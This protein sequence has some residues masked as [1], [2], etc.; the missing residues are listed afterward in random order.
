MHSFAPSRLTW[1]ALALLISLAIISPKQ[2]VAVA[3]NWAGTGNWD[4][5][6]NWGGTVP[7]AGDSGAINTGTAT[8]NVVL[9]GSPTIT[10]G[11]TGT[12]IHPSFA[13]ATP[14][15]G[16]IT[17]QSGGTID[18]TGA[19]V[20]DQT[21]TFFDGGS[22]ITRSAGD[23]LGQVVSNPITF[24]AGTTTITGVAGSVDWS[25]YALT[26]TGSISGGVSANFNVSPTSTSFRNAFQI[27]PSVANSY[28]GT[29]TVSGV[30][31]VHGVL[32]LAGTGALQNATG[33][34]INPNGVLRLNTG[35]DLLGA[36]A[37]PVV[38][39]ARLELGGHST[40]SGTPPTF[41][42]Q[43]GS[44]L[45][46]GDSDIQ[47]ST[48]ATMEVLGGQTLNATGILGSVDWSP[49]ALTLKGSLQGSGLLNV[50]PTATNQKG[51]LRLS[52]TVANSFTGTVAIGGTP[53]IK[54]TLILEGTG[55]LQNIGAGAITINPYGQLRINTSTDPLPA[56]YLL[57]VNADARMEWGGTATYTGVKPTI[58]F[59]N[60]ST[61]GRGDGDLT[62]SIMTENI[63]INGTVKA[64]KIDGTVDWQPYGLKLNGALSGSGTLRIEP[65]LTGGDKNALVIN[66][67][68]ANSFNGTVQV[69]GNAVSRGTLGLEGTGAL[70]NVSVLTVENFGTIR[71]GSA[72][73]PLPSAFVVNVQTGGRAEWLGTA[74]YNVTPPTLLLQN[75]TFLGRSQNDELGTSKEVLSLA[76]GATV[77]A[78]FRG[79][80]LREF[81]APN[82]TGGLIGDNTTTLHVAPP[83]VGSLLGVMQISS[84]TG[85][86]GFAGNVLVDGNSAAV[87]GVLLLNGVS[88]LGTA[89]VDIGA[90]GIVSVATNGALNGV[91][92]VNLQTNGSLRF[93]QNGGSTL[94]NTTI[95][96]TGIIRSERS[97]ASN[98]EQNG[99]YT[100][101]S[102]NLVDTV[103][104]PGNSA[105]TLTF[106]VT[107][108]G[109]SADSTMHMELGASSDLIDVNGL[110]DLSAGPTLELAEIAGL[111][112]GSY[113]IATY[114][115]LIGTFSSILGPD[116]GSYR[117]LSID[118]GT[119]LNSQITVSI[120]MI[121]APEPSSLLMLTCGALGL[122][123][124][125]R[126][127]KAAQLNG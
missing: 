102:L 123:V 30:P 61:F 10:V 15:A 39:G 40:F 48:T 126:R 84:T 112:P 42:F 49:Y 58:T 127:R 11:G 95:T 98:E 59:N 52:P 65:T 69:A 93:H 46:R 37:I 27:K 122:A 55:A 2:A 92:S 7:G 47:S 103:L 117:F 57:N 120:E 33:V 121:P 45:G 26:M 22:K 35:T 73:D 75:G 80:V 63:V 77:T 100:Q 105:G 29:A 119:G 106:N 23:I 96:G 104:S 20:L 114:D 70:A 12:L 88:P 108:L 3:Y 51:A 54:G 53:S 24:N 28:S 115:S 107:T 21:P 60:G 64:T 13:A 16:S 113:V 118:Y 110:L 99:T 25:N 79:T 71:F 36:L 116:S 101:M 14:I 56:G 67:T 4:T 9:A 8:A 62:N 43:T 90:F 1:L 78:G 111:A 41:S 44:T 72:T 82:F 18:W 32:A 5:A 19:S 124:R 81:Y 38:S 97:I 86:A 31:S 76:S 109:L 66:S 17:A 6:A 83:S 74:T 94:S 91:T 85:N 125:S 68:S 34:T 89:K 50:A 87:P